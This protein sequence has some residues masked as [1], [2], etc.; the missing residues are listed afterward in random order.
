[1]ER[2]S[3]CVHTCVLGEVY[4]KS[5]EGGE[6]DGQGMSHSFCVVSIDWRPHHRSDGWPLINAG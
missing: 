3:V 1:M 5:K 6:V 2:K 4:G